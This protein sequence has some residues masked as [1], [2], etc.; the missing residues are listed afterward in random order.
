MGFFDGFTGIITQPYRGARDDGV[1]GF[2][3]GVGTATVGFLFKP[4]AGIFGIVGYPLK[5]VDQ[6]FRR[7]SDRGRWRYVLA[8][9]YLMGLK[10]YDTCP[11]EERIAIQ[12]RWT[13]LMAKRGKKN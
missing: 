6:E 12:E 10:A 3:K 2:A 1:A 4:G 13:T 9:R 11:E 8:S 7:R 5:G